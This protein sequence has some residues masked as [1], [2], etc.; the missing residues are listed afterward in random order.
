[1]VDR[2]SRERLKKKVLD[3]WENEGG[4][5][6]GEETKKRRAKL[7]LPSDDRPNDTG[8]TPMKPASNS[9]K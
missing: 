8:N 1:M 6:S 2:I 4:R 5:L 3:R 9:T 7:S